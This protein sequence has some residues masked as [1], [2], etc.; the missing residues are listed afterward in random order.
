MNKFNK[1]IK[2]MVSED[3][4][5]IVDKIRLIKENLPFKTVGHTEYFTF[6][7]G[8]NGDFAGEE[9]YGL[10]QGNIYVV[11]IKVLEHIIQQIKEGDLYPSVNVVSDLDNGYL[12]SVAEADDID[13]IVC[14]INVD[15]Y[16]HPNCMTISVGGDYDGHSSFLT[17]Y[18]LFSPDWAANE[19]RNMNLNLDLQA[20]EVERAAR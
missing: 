11:A 18:A 15:N 12:L 7:S 8:G 6:V 10:V 3:V 17:E 1:L 20:S 16:E 4:G 5:Q 9:M 13:K 14:N 2:Q 19:A